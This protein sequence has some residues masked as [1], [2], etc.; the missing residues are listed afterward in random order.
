MKLFI[1]GLIVNDIIVKPVDEN[2]LKRDST[3]LKDLQ[4]KSGG[5]ALNVAVACAKLGADVELFGRVGND[6]FGDFLLDEAKKNGVG[7]NG[8]VRDYTSV[9]STSIVM[10]EKNGERHFLYY[11]DANDRFSNE[12]IDLTKLQQKRGIFHL[13]GVLA[14]N[15]FDDI[16][17]EK[18][19]SEV[20]KNNIITSM[21][22]TWDNEDLWLKKIHNSLYQLDI[23]IP[24][25]E[26][27]KKISG[28]NNIYDIADFFSKYNLKKFVLK[29]GK[30]GCY[31]T[32][33]SN[34]FKIPTFN[35]V[36]VVDTTGAGDSFVGGFLTGIS[37]GI[38][39]E[40]SLIL[41][42]AV[43]SHCVSML[44]ASD[45]IKTF[46]QTMNFINKNKGEEN[47]VIS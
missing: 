25:L 2:I 35:C 30:D 41:G 38:E 7:T 42:N 17:L 47:N 21:D 32:D 37:K 43:A 19:L 15:G 12:D 6:S 9:T 18:L 10:V 22:V 31:A 45:G 20:K 4:I 13:S 40:D 16:N 46:E 27:A 28:K 24:S 29:L 33:F 26:E 5:D 34:E 11:G 3:R 36:K 44:G 39:F 8:V 14:L 1:A 23:F